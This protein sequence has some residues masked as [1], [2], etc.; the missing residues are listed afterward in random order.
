M[1]DLLRQM[2]LL[3]MDPAPLLPTE[4][5]ALYRPLHGGA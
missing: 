1:G 2:P 3:F 4:P 5:G